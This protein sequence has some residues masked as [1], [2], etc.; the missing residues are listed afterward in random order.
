MEGPQQYEQLD[1]LSRYEAGVTIVKVPRGPDD[2]V[3]SGLFMGTRSGGAHVRIAVPQGY[4]DIPV[5]EFLELNDAEHLDIP[6][7]EESE[8]E[9]SEHVDL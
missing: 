3:E 1:P 4:K 2:T 9:H 8:S 7:N 5:Q 6:L